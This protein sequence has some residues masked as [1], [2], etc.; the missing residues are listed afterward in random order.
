[1]TT[2][3]TL[4]LHRKK[5]QVSISSSTLQQFRDL[6]MKEQLTPFHLWEI[7]TYTLT[8]HAISPQM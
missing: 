3:K 8:G 5:K 2:Q 7:E 4:L 6:F 1:M